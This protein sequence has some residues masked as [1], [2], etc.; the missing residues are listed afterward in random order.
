MLYDTLLR[1]ENEPDNKQL[2]EWLENVCQPHF[3]MVD[4]LVGTFIVNID[5]PVYAKKLLKVL[6]K[7]NE[8]LPTLVVP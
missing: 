3:Q 4:G 5:E 1:V 6:K 7:L 2:L 8:Y